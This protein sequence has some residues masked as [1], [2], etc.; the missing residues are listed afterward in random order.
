MHNAP[1]F[2]AY[3]PNEVAVFTNEELELI[4]GSLPKR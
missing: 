3:Y 2:R 4:A 1:H